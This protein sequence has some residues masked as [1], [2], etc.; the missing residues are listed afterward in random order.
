MLLY[1]FEPDESVI[2]MIPKSIVWGAIGIFFGRLCNMITVLVCN[3]GSVN[4]MVLQNF[5]QLFICAAV[6]T[7]LRNLHHYFGWT[8]QNTTAGLFFTAFF[9]GTQFKIMSNIANNAKYA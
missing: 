1:M 3:I 7:L 9:F 2:R 6:I 4:N 8:W 5:I